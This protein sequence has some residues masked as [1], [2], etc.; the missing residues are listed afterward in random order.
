MRLSKSS[1]RPAISRLEVGV[2]VVVVL[3]FLGLGLIFLQ[4]G[5][6]GSNR[7]QCELNLKMMGEGVHKFHDIHKALPASCIDKKYATWA[8]QIAPYL[9]EPRGGAL[10]QWDLTLPYYEQ[11]EPV[12]TKILK[13]YFCPARG[14]TARVST[15]EKPA[16]GKPE[17]K[18]Y[19]GA[20]G[21]YAGSAGT[22]ADGHAWDSPQANGAIIPAK[23][24]Q[25]DGDKILR[26]QGQ[27]TLQDLANSRGL[28]NT[29]VIGEKHVPWEQ[30]GELAVG[31]GSLYNGDYPANFARIGGPGH[32]LAQD[33]TAPFNNNFGSYHLDICQFLM[34]DLTVRQVAN[35]ISEQVL[36]E[37]SNRNP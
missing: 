12:R 13:V 31:D 18:A 34:A 37:L 32:G 3:I 17:L 11:P 1:R 28:S 4:R 5:W 8:V 36:G 25:R 19:P 6:E 22:N 33:S 16:D 24:V 21:D 30:K 15:T 10:Q 29:I 26:W 9:P 7:V 14:R 2:V 35:S 23:E 20:L 27:V